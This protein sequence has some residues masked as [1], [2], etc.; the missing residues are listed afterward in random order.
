MAVPEER[1]ENLK[2][3]VQK[4]LQSNFTLTPIRWPNSEFDAGLIDE[5]IEVRPFIVG[6]RFDRQTRQDR[7]GAQIKLACDINIKIK[8]KFMEKGESDRD[9]TIRDAL[10]AVFKERTAIVVKDYVTN[11][12]TP[13]TI[14]TATVF[15]WDENDLG[16]DEERVLT[17]YNVSPTILF[18]QEWQS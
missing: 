5:W 13:P 4:H 1:L 9:I 16:P 14:G 10:F 2:A 17:T 8:M 12:T 6:R 11:P 7:H 15:A 3:S 18:E